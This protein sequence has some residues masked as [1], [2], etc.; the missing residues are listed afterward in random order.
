[1]SNNNKNIM[2]KYNCCK[3]G[4]V[5][6]TSEYWEDVASEMRERQL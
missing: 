3:C 6:D 4:E 1:M 2:A 5:V